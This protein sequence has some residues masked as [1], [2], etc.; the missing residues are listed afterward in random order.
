MIKSILSLFRERVFKIIPLMF[1]YSLIL[2]AALLLPNIEKLTAVNIFIIIYTSILQLI[3]IRIL[4]D[5][6]DLKYDREHN[7]NRVVARGEI[8][9]RS[10]LLVVLILLLC[11]FIPAILEYK[12]SALFMLIPSAYIYLIF[13]DFYQKSKKLKTVMLKS[14]FISIQ[15]LSLFFMIKNYNVITLILIFTLQTILLIYSFF[16]YRR[17]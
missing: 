14:F 15:F 5:I 11:S 1:L 12:I 4:D 7:P 16:K 17:K 2:T 13:K 10:C 8:S 6:T 3:I 9:V